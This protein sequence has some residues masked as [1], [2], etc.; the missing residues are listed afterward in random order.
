[1]ITLHDGIPVPK[2]IDF[3]IAKATQQK[4]TEKTVFTQLQQFIGT[5]AYMSPE[6]AEMSG[7]DIDTR[8][9]VYSLGV[10][11]YELLTGK[12]P[13][14]SK[15]IMAVG[16][17]EMRRYIREVEP[18]KPSTRISVLHQE[19]QSTLAAHRKVLPDKLNRVIRGELDWIVMKALEKDRTRRYESASGFAADI[20]HHLNHEPVAAAAPSLFYQVRKFSRRHRK[21][22]ATVSLF[23]VTLIIAVVVSIWLLFRATK[24]EH[25]ADQRAEMERLAKEA[26]TK[27]RQRAAKSEENAQRELYYANINVADRYIEDGDIDRALQALT[28]CPPQ[29]RHWEWGRLLYLCHQD[30]WSAK[31]ASSSSSVTSAIQFSPGN[32]QLATIDAANQL[33]VWQTLDGKEEWTYG[34]KTHRVISIH[35][36]PDGTKL[37]LINGKGAIELWDT[38]LWSRRYQIDPV[39]EEKFSQVRFSGDRIVAIKGSFRVA[40]FEADSG[41]VLTSLQGKPTAGFFRLHIGAD[42]QSIVAIGPDDVSYWQID[43]QGNIITSNQQPWPEGSTLHADNQEFTVWRTAEEGLEVR[44]IATGEMLPTLR[45][46]QEGIRRVFFSP[47]NR[48]LCAVDDNDTARILDLP[49]GKE[50]CAFHDSFS[51]AAFSIDGKRIVTIGRNRVV[52]IWDTANGRELRALKGHRDIASTATFSPDGRWVASGDRNGAIK[53]WRSD[54][55]RERLQH[56]DWFMGVAISPNGK[57]MASAH[58]DG[59]AKIWDIESGAQL[60]TLRGHFELVRGI[61]FSPDGTRIAT[62][63]SDE[64]AKVWDANTG[65]ELLTF[66]SHT[67]GIITVAFSPGGRRIATGGYDL[68]AKIWD[69]SSGQE[70]INLKG[71]SHTVKSLVW[72]PTKERIATSSRDETA[73]IWDTTNGSELLTLEGHASNVVAI[74]YSPDGK[75]IVT[76]GEDRTLRVWDAES[77]NEISLMSSKGS[78]RSIAFSPDGERL[79]AAYSEGQASLGTPSIDIWELE[80]GREL[81]SIKAH[82]NV[83]PAA[84]WSPSSDRIISGSLDHTAW[85]WESFPYRREDHPGRPNSLLLE[86]TQRYAVEY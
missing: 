69:A 77:G 43:S 55:G 84:A 6:Q 29:Y 13:F 49:S 4:L 54:H 40:L 5:P 62:V 14:D 38:R 85:V 3:G 17:D 20:H 51:R 48:L 7:L 75:L 78:V 65:K 18:P 22:V 21:V 10:L 73:K 60:H 67:R 83:I 64:T 33:H 59:L 82:D 26:E 36:S 53:L 63:S 79:A 41:R 72:H 86:R 61:D 81:L 42:G 12:T 45:G 70:L 2:V 57:H 11:L 30:V 28:E 50:Q 35:Y 44:R 58:A 19:E 52:R 15:E 32:D 37:A 46:L 31:V 23:T 9:D 80:S 71:H 68:I 56:W 39:A 27:Q 76:A 1:M 8:S 74:T 66:R 34:G 16:Y 25:L 24:A 47:D